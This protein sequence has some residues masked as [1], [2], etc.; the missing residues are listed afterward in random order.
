M[1]TY[2]KFSLLA[3]V[4]FA[5]QQEPDITEEMLD[6]DI[7]F[8][9]SLYEPEKYL[10][11]Y[12][13]PEPTPEEALKPVIIACHGYTATTFE[14]SEF[15]E[16]I[17]DRDDVYVS[18]VLLAGHGRSYE[19]FKE[20]SWQDWQSAITEEYRRLEAAGYKNIHL[21]GSSTSCALFLELL[22]SDYFQGR[23]VPQ[24]ILMVD[25]IVIPSNKLLPLI[26]VVGPMLGYM[27]SE[28]TAEEDKVYYRFRPQ[29][30]LQQLQELITLVRKE[31]ERGIV[32]P[33]DC[34][35]K[36][37]KSTKDPTAD[38]VSAVLI[39]KGLKTSG[40][41]NIEV[42]LIASDLHVFTRLELLNDYNFQDL[43]NQQKTF[44]DI[45]TRVLL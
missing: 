45:L 23:I 9:P 34:Q 37:Y 4:C 1:K 27:E 11:S 2:I 39:Y 20:S 28:Q 30:T 15:R 6:G 13:K 24:N 43:E 38:P 35:V 33:A 36:V 3:L 10:L 26:G 44:Q 14:W 42:E 7:L 19:D 40:G 5:C 22:D 25:P 41:E 18:Q 12:A 16:W 31:L 17:G 32:L 21:L 8:D 29:E